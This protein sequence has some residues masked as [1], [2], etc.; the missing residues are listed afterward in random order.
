MAQNR[1]PTHPNDNEK[2][3]SF[4]SADYTSLPAGVV[5]NNPYLTSTQVSGPVVL[6]PWHHQTMPVLVVS[7]AIAL[8]AGSLAGGAYLALNPV[9]RP[10]GD[11]LF[12]HITLKNF[13]VA[14]TFCANIVG[15]VA[16][17]GIAYGARSH[18]S[19][20]LVHSGVDLGEYMDWMN[21]SQA[22]LPRKASL[23]AL[24]A[25]AVFG[26]MNVW[27]SSF[28][29]IFAAATDGNKNVTISTAYT[30]YAANAADLDAGVRSG[31]I[32]LADPAWQVLNSQDYEGLISTTLSD[33]IFQSP[34]KGFMNDT[35]FSKFWST[36]SSSVDDLPSQLG[37]GISPSMLQLSTFTSLLSTNQGPGVNLTAQEKL[38]VTTGKNVFRAE[39]PVAQATMNCTSGGMTFSS[40]TQSA[41]GFTSFYLNDTLCGPIP[42]TGV[43]P[44]PTLQH[45][46]P[47]GDYF[48]GSLYSCYS[49]STGQAR[50]GLYI[51]IPSTQSFV[52]IGVC[53]GKVTAGWVGNV[54]YV[55]GTDHYTLP[56]NFVI[57]DKVDATFI[58]E[59]ILDSN[60][61]SSLPTVFF[62]ALNKFGKF[63]EVPGLNEIGDSAAQR[64]LVPANQ[65]LPMLK[66]LS[67]AVL[68][69]SVSKMTNAITINS[70]YQTGQLPFSI[71]ESHYRTT[72]EYSANRIGAKKIQLAWLAIPALLL[73]ILII[74]LLSVLRYRPVPMNPLDPISMMLIAQNSP[75]TPHADG[76]CMGELEH[77]RTP[78]EKI[79]YRALNQQHLGFV[80]GPSTYD[81]P[82]LGR[83]YGSTH[84]STKKD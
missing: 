74:S 64:L 10:S 22:G 28:N 65:T 18:L 37:S 79:R 42:G 2:G 16:G 33:L 51:V 43:S 15:V 25:L 5:P 76:A 63:F 39:V 3:S 66:T 71:D 8:V 14:I 36:L 41:Y 19:R 49:N 47:T 52:T 69:M 58:S 17:M 48:A 44:D 34:A 78:K 38:L 75:A 77:A 55:E 27:G 6:S 61:L 23:R 73:I 67:E 20:K 81:P 50:V 21:L 83:M 32:N 60:W 31:L 57:N 84:S 53:T 40:F 12:P 9:L 80:W 82:V 13:N 7:L 59:A 72:I 11:L 68:A 62:G 70:N 29:A 45:T 46:V 1:P 24:L 35:Q 54:T 4:A 30:T 26:I 56:A